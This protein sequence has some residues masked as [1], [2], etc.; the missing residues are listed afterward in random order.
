MKSSGGP[1]VKLL[2]AKSPKMIED[3]AAQAAMGM[4]NDMLV[5]AESKEDLENVE[6]FLAAFGGE[7]VSHV[8]GGVIMNRHK[9][10]GKSQA[11]CEEMANTYAA[12]YGVRIAETTREHVKKMFN[13]ESIQQK[14]IIKKP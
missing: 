3:L 1:P 13:G 4:V 2:R 10:K 12:D 6:T 5:G 11:V 9:M 14:H 8:C 7:F